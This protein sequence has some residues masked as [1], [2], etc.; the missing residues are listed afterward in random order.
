VI[1]FS[2]GAYLAP[3]VGLALPSVKQVI[4][5]HGRFWAKDFSSAPGFELL[6]LNGADDQVVDPKLSQA[7]H[8]KLLESG[9]KGEF[10]MLPGVGHE[11][12]SEVREQLAR[13]L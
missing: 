5:L 8:G 2:Q 13:W 12:N 3:H 11:I 7:E 10:I 1:G 4:G 6:Q 9:G